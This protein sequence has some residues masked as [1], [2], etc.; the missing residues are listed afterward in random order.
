MEPMIRRKIS[1]SLVAT[2][3]LAGAA[4]TAAAG[5]S[6]TTTDVGEPLSITLTVDRTSGRAGVDAFTYH[7]EAAG[8]DLLGVVLDF[9]DGQVDS[10][11]AQGAARA[12]ATRSHVYASPGTYSAHA[13]AMEAF[14]SVR[15]DTVVVAVQAP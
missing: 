15:A 10:L 12:A 11:A 1:A 3:V 13:R 14:G 7:Y 5:C 6:R 9:G 4:L 8:T 2:A